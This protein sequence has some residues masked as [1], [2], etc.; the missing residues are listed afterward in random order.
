VRPWNGKRTLLKK[1]LKFCTRAKADFVLI[2]HGCVKWVCGDIQY[3]SVSLK[4]RV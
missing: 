1:L 3:A 2:F 4:I